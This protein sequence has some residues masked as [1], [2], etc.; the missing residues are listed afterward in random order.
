MELELCYAPIEC[1]EGSVRLAS[2][3]LHKVLVKMHRAEEGTGVQ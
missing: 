1:L 3:S 2:L